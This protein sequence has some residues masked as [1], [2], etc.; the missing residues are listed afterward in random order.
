VQLVAAFALTVVLRAGL[1]AGPGQTGAE[2]E[3]EALLAKTTLQAPMAEVRVVLEGPDATVYRLEE[4]TVTLDGVTVAFSMGVD[5]GPSMALVT[6]VDAGA[7]WALSDTV[8]AGPAFPIATVLA[9]DA[10]W[11][12][13]A[14]SDAG[15]LL[16]AASSIDAGAPFAG[17]QVP[18][19]DHVVAARLVY[20]GQPTGPYP[21]QQGPRWV[22]P[23]RVPF[24]ASHGLRFTVR[25]VVE[26]NA[27]APAAQ[28]LVLR[29]EVEPEMVAAVDDA[30]LP[31]PPLPRLPPPPVPTSVTASAPPL[32][33]A[34][35]LAA[36]PTKKKP[37]KKV[38][39]VTSTT[40][41]VP[42]S[43]K[44]SKAAAGVPGSGEAP[45]SL[46]EATARL[47]NAL[48]APLDAGA[49]PAGAPR[50]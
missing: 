20:R 40:G 15:P 26:M 1:D 29:P 8:D 36:T 35:P 34:T 3:I 7:P 14:V 28:R 45:V 38:A 4:S 37:K 24:Q 11:P 5:A 21:W 42:A 50:H 13:S 6:V 10:G 22:L 43:A 17:T 32:V 23:G 46:E 18:D 16:S 48:A 49:A 31:P 30:P 47:R 41:G 27:Q 39:R 19:G 44:A 12:L 2:A 33:M 9:T 25:L